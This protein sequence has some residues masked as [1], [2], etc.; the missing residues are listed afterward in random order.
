MS[1]VEVYDKAEYHS[2][3]N[4]PEGLPIEQSFVHTGLF[5]GWLIRHGMVSEEV[6]DAA[7]RDFKKRRRT[8]PQIFRGLGG[9]LLS[10][11]LTD[12]GNGFAKA[13]FDFGHGA[14]VSEYG[15]LLAADL[16]SPYEVEDSWENFE[17]L[18]ALLDRRFQAWREGRL[19]A[20]VEADA[21][22][23]NAD[24]V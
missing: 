4:W 17:K 23:R 14:Y 8:G 2:G 16:G 18:C 3:G 10:S 21:P 24:S 19:D 12:D 13:Y 5:L 20:A 22:P 15:R 1:D 9:G 7:V 6:D 11:M